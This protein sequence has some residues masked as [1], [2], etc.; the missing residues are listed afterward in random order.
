MGPSFAPSGGSSFLGRFSKG[1]DMRGVKEKTKAASATLS[2]RMNSLGS[3]LMSVTK[4]DKKSDDVVSFE[5]P[6]RHGA[7]AAVPAPKRSGPPPG[8]LRCFTCAILMAFPEGVLQVKCPGCGTINNTP[9]SEAATGVSPASQIQTTGE[10]SMGGGSESGV[11]VACFACASQIMCAAGAGVVP[12][13][14]CDTPNPLSHA[15]VSR[16]LENS[17]AVAPH[18]WPVP[19]VKHSQHPASQA[20]ALLPAQAQQ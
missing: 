10:S 18:L 11:V 2:T 15:Q 4:K 20:R 12:C 6:Q 19:C 7:A 16:A 9:S 8:Q 5:S 1:L 17:R 13:S 3:S 14:V